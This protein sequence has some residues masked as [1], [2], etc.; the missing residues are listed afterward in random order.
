MLYVFIFN[1][2]SNKNFFK[3]S[4]AGLTRHGTLSTGRTSRVHSCPLDLSNASRL[5]RAFTAGLTLAIGS[6]RSLQMR[7][8]LII[9]PGVYIPLKIKNI[10]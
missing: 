6:P 7:S 9:A 4:M 1:G 5:P 10:F 2:A 8:I 3:I